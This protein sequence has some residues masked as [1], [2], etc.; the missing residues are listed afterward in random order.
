ML[1]SLTPG[2]D[3]TM[4]HITED[5]PKKCNAKKR[6]CPIEK[7][8]GSENSPHFSNEQDAQKFYEN[9]MSENN[10]NVKT[11]S[12]PAEHKT[13]AN[14]AKGTKYEKVAA[15][16]IPKSVDKE[17]K[18]K[19]KELY[20]ADRDVLSASDSIHRLA[21]HKKVYTRGH[22]YVWSGSFQSAYEKI[23]A[24]LNK[25]PDHTFSQKKMYIEKYNNA[26]SHLVNVEKA[27]NE[28]NDIGE[29]GQWNRAFL[30]TSTN[31]HVHKTM[32]CSTC[33]KGNKTTQFELISEYSGDKEETIVNDAG[34]RACTV[35]YHSAPVESLSRKTKIFSEDEQKATDEKVKKDAEKLVKQQKAATNAPTVSGEFLNVTDNDSSSDSAKVLKTERAASM[36]LTDAMG[37]PSYSWRKKND[38]EYKKARKQQHEEEV[39][40]VVKALS[41]K[42]GVSEEQL[43]S[44][45]KKKWKKKHS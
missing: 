23:S 17:M 45:A 11:I 10:A 31:G 14:A 26:A 2:D 4:F 40:L 27:I 21:H 34:E 3:C 19:L 7:A 33:N 42:K 15:K 25:A 44:E 41:E 38:E 5:G 6:E 32:D 30:A 22:D 24:D 43:I 37:G 16:D 1:K 8:D 9:K 28:L 35:C 18:E 36:W 20:K 29:K 39:S 12:T 13:W